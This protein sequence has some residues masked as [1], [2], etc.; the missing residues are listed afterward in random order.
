MI[1]LNPFEGQQE[2]Y[3]YKDR[4]DDK[5][6]ISGLIVWVSMVSITLSIYGLMF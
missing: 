1:D 4:H 3:E 6:S 5:K 2:Q